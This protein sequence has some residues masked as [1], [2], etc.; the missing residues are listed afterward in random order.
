M[1]RGSVPPLQRTFDATLFA[2]EWALARLADLDKDIA[3]LAET[4]PYRTPVGW[5]RCFRGI[6][7]CRP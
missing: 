6:G 7:T 1:A 2:L 5:L 3:A 4:A